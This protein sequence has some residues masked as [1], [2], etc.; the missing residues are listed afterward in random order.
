MLHLDGCGVEGEVG[1]CGIGHDAH[2]RIFI[3]IVEVGDTILH[4][5]FIIC[6][7][8]FAFQFVGFYIHSGLADEPAVGG[9][10]VRDDG[11]AGEIHLGIYL[12]YIQVGL[13]GVGEVAAHALG[14]QG[15]GAELEVVAVQVE[16]CQVLAGAEVNVAQLVLGECQLVQTGSLTQVNLLE[17]VATQ[18]DLPYIAVQRDRSQLVVEEV[19]D[20]QV[21]EL[22]G[23]ETLEL[24][25]HEVQQEDVLGVRAEVN[26]GEVIA[27]QV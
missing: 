26:A 6:Y 10:G 24:V 22:R 19:E 18:I 9:E 4:L 2:E 16:G 13:V 27:L 12:L 7:Q 21:G 17:L 23:V 8:F 11:L 20:A 3:L 1:Q 25:V 14:I 5:V 15:Q